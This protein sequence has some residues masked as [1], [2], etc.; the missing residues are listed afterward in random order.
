MATQ[1][2][3]PNPSPVTACANELAKWITDSPLYI[4]NPPVTP[5]RHVLIAGGTAQRSVIDLILS[6]NPGL[7]QSVTQRHARYLRSD[8]TPFTVELALHSTAPLPRPPDTRARVTWDHQRCPEAWQDSLAPVLAAALAPLQPA[9]VSLTQPLPAGSSPQA[10]VDA[11]YQQFEQALTAACVDVVGTKVVRPTS[12]PWLA[13][14]GVKEARRDKISALSTVQSRP[15]DASARQHLKVARREWRKVSCDAKRHCFTALCDQ[16]AAPDSKLRWALFKRLQPSAF[17]PLTSIANRSTGDLPLDHATSMDNLCAAFVANGTPPPPANAAAHSLLQQQVASW[18]CPSNPTIPPHPS[19]AWSFSADEVKA[20]CT[21]QHTNS[22]PGPDSIL[23][24]FLKHAGPAV[25]SALSLLYSFSWSHSVLPQA[26]REANVM[27]LYKGSGGKANAG[28]YRPISMTSIIIRTFEHL[29]Q[30]RL[31]AELEARNFFASYQFGFRKQRSTSDAVHFLLTAIQGVLR[32]QTTGD[33]LQVPVLFL[34][35]QKAF[36]RVDHDIL[37]HRVHIAGING[38]AWLWLRAFLTNRRM[39]CVDS[40]EHSAWHTI[41][42]GVPQ[43]C[44]LSPALFLIFINDVQLTILNDPQCSHVAPVFFADDGALGPN[45]FD[46]AQPPARAFEARYTQHLTRAM[47]HLDDWCTASRMRFGA[48]KSQ[49]VVFSMRK[50]IDPA[51]YSALQLCNFTVS[52]TAEYKYLGVFLSS[53]LSWTRATANALTKAKKSSALVTRVALVAR[54]LSFTAI[55]ILVLGLVIPTFEYGI[56]Y[57]GRAIDLTATEVTSLQAQVATPLRVALS[58]PRTTHQLGTLLLSN[59]PTV[60]SLVLRAQLGHL[61][62]F[63]SLPAD[64]PTRRLHTLTLNHAITKQQPPWTALVPSAALPTSVYLAASVLPRLLLD[65]T[66]L[67]ATTRSNLTL[68]PLQH[69]RHGVEYWE[70]TGSSRRTWAQANYQS[71]HLTAALNWAA[72]A[73]TKLTRSLIGQIRAR[74]S[75]AE[76]V[77]THAPANPP[78]PG[79]PP[80]AHATTAPLIHCMPQAGA[81]PPFLARRSPDTHGQQTSRARALLGRS[82]TGTVRL[83]FAKAAEASTISTACTRCSTPT[84]PVDDTIP[85]MLLHCLRHLVARSQLAST[86]TGL[87]LPVTLSTIL[88]ASR[89]PRPFTGSLLP[90]LLRATS[91]FLTAIHVDRSKEQLVPLDT[92]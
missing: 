84:N 53:R 52:T 60:S 77:A 71:N 66:L 37:L 40:A 68:P 22:A 17:S 5:T 34:D 41:E 62:R 56:L 63:C 24:V 88:V 15:S 72:A 7:V 75:H 91:A 39:R 43:G 65:P 26:W 59:V 70:H 48:E 61:L 36:D 74:H 58:L 78:P 89:P 85:H 83:R 35:I 73:A 21:Q 49:I 6:N 57:W 80:I 3:L 86:L 33:A 10:T 29:I 8:H 42:Y 23:P 54:S 31:I 90:Q 92:G 45:P 67:D 46:P 76:W 13:F 2:P 14:P 9:L 79:T 87:G 16:I 1:V 20:Q 69:W 81:L 50:Q 51:P 12:S 38:R 25:W 18:A 4:C 82:R 32:R 28:S 11:V 55:R 47:R 30:R 44:V 19:D 27:A 64:H